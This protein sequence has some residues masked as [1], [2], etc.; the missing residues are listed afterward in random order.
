MVNFSIIR[1]LLFIISLYYI[2]RCL[3]SKAPKS[4]IRLTPGLRIAHTSYNLYANKENIF[5]SQT[6]EKGAK[7][8]I[9][10]VF[11]FQFFPR[12]QIF[13]FKIYFQA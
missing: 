10:I 13:K 7:I 12:K 2:I 1:C 5:T 3:W 9:K 11:L 8:A 4:F 6:N